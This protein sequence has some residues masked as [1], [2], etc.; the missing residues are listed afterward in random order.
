[1]LIHRGKALP[2]RLRS[3]LMAAKFKHGDLVQSK[4]GGPQMVVDSVHAPIGS[5]EIYRYDCTWWVGKKHERTR[6]AEPT[7][8]PWPDDGSR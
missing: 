2:L 5:G 6:F 7:L 8:D 3:E 1:M 4:A